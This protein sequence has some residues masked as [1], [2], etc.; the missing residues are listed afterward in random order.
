M[1]ERQSLLSPI[2]NTIERWRASCGIWHVSS[3]FRVLGKRYFT[4]PW[5]TTESRMT[6]TQERSAGFGRDAG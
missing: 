1:E 2:A 6:W 5:V 3:G 4:L